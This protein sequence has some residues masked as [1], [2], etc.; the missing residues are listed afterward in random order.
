MITFEIITEVSIFKVQIL[1]FSYMSGVIFEYLK[2]K[3]NSISP[4]KHLLLL[5]TRFKTK[6]C[7]EVISYSG[8]LSFT[9]IPF[10][11]L[12]IGLCKLI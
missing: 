5:H 1:N 4:F 11:T 6:N 10:K 3:T 12:K 9:E 7:Q 2:F 8:N